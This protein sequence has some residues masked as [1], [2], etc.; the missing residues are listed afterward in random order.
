MTPKDSY[1]INSG[2]SVAVSNTAKMSRVMA[3]CPRGVKV[4]LLGAGGV[5]V[6]A[7]YDLDPF[8]VEWAALPARADC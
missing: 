8:W 5:L 4:L 3:D 1:R 7:N 2:R 6:I